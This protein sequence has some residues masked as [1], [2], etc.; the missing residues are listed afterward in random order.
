MSLSH[1]RVLI[2]ELSNKD[3]YIVS[4]EDTLIISD[5]KSDVFVDNNDK[6]TKHTRHIYIRVKLVTNS[7][8]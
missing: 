2:R 1:F 6:D 4:E 3:T 5:G 7:E 8:N